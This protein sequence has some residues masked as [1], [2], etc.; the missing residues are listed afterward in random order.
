MNLERASDFF[1][2]PLCGA[3]VEMHG[4]PRVGIPPGE[5]EA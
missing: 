3:M 1:F 4:W 5:E 2:F